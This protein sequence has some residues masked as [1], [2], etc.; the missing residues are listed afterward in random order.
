MDCFH[1]HSST[2]QVRTAKCCNL[3][4]YASCNTR[5]S[6]M[7][8]LQTRLRVPG[9]VANLPKPP[10]FQLRGVRTHAGTNDKGPISTTSFS[11]DSIKCPNFVTYLQSNIV[12]QKVLRYDR[13]MYCLHVSGRSSILC[14]LRFSSDFPLVIH[15]SFSS[16]VFRE[17]VL[18]LNFPACVL[19]FN[20][21]PVSF[22]TASSSL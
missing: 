16:I 13:R 21:A 19:H 3:S 20:R 7:F 9:N 10:R 22:S 14:L 6:S 11:E 18:N 1:A 15:F 8:L 5:Y 2:A 12:T 4:V 17:H